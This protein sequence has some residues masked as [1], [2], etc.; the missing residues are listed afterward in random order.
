MTF[1]EILPPGS[2]METL[3][4]LSVAISASATVFVFYR[5]LLWRDPLASRMKSLTE[6]R[7]VLT[8]EM[9]AA[10]RR[11]R[12]SESSMDI[13]QGV[14]QRFNLL[15]SR[16]AEK[17]T[18]KLAQAGWRS[19]NAVVM[20]LFLRLVLPLAFG[21]AAAILVY[22][23][24]VVNLPP[25]KAAAVLIAATL[26]GSYGPEVFIKNK[27]TKRQHELRKGLPDALDLLVICAEAGQSLDA[28]LNRVAREL[29]KSAPALA[30]ELAL[31]SIEL[32]LLPE[33]RKALENLA[34]RADIPSIRGVINT[35]AQTEK[36]GT[37]L[38]Q[39]LRILA[40]EFRN[41]RMMRAETKAARLPAILTVPM[42]VFILPPLFIVLIGPAV[43]RTIDTLSRL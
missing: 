7:K 9:I 11:R 18:L 15:R 41:E 35:L 12:R 13:A 43:L 10:P 5:T 8:A 29:A 16:E 42:I 31:T 26:L 38:A 21:L 4:I 17:A 14:V 6:R 27:I 28:A 19:H 32:G 24:H 39:S 25:L 20:Y 23:L 40:S 1:A 37:P 3:L 33:R 22:G 34:K 30:D 2:L 36:Y